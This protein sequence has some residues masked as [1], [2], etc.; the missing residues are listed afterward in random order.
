MKP[1]DIFGLVIRF[2]SIIII[3]WGLWYVLAGL[4][5]V[6]EILTHAYRAE[7]EQYSPLSYLGMGLPTVTFGI[8]S[9][10]FAD[11]IVRVTYRDR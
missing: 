5:T 8:V 11:L 7:D 3:L 2:I 4:V 1:S 6:M 10:V 9:L